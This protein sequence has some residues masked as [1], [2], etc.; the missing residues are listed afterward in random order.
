MFLIRNFNAV[1]ISGWVDDFN[2]EDLSVL[3]IEP[4]TSAKS[5]YVMV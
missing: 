3:T 4:F 2:H 1:C 5:D